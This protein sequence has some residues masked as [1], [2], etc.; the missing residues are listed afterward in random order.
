ME[1]D[2]FLYAKD[3]PPKSYVVPKCIECGQEMRGINPDPYTDHST[4]FI[5][6]MCHIRAFR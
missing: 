5:C 4:R 3:P 2:G 6:S 1:R